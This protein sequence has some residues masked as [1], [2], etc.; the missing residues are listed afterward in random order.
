ML[1]GLGFS[2]PKPVFP[3]Q[4]GINWDKPVFPSFSRPNLGKTGKNYILSSKTFLKCDYQAKI[5]QDRQ[6]DNLTKKLWAHNPYFVEKVFALIL[7]IIIYSAL[8]LFMLHQLC[9]QAMSKVV[10]L[11]LCC[12]GFGL[13]THKPEIVKWFSHC[14]GH[15][16]FWLVQGHSRQKAIQKLTSCFSHHLWIQK[17]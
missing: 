6:E 13:W 15:A 9:C 5:E 2:R 17:N 4:N 3:V 11:L 1:T 12:T 8:T 10:T 7:I 14:S 16:L